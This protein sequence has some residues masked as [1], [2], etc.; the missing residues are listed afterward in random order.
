MPKSTD[1]AS[2]VKDAIT[3][4]DPTAKVT[5]RELTS[6]GSIV[7]VVAQYLTDGKAV[8]RQRAYGFV[9][10]LWSWAKHVPVEML[11]RG[12][13]DPDPKVRLAALMALKVN[14]IGTGYVYA[15][16]RAKLGPIIGPLRA[17]PDKRIA[18]QAGHVCTLLELDVSDTSAPV[19][20][21]KPAATPASRSSAPRK[22]R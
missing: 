11:L 9:A 5:L 22:R 1:I 12:L 20:P 6:A 2:L 3:R 10:H 16:D 18:E 14:Q 19:K 7:P 13:D 15:K 8:H 4:N 17:D 21:A